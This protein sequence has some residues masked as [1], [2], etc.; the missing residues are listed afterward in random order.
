[1]TVEVKS[2]KMKISHL[3]RDFKSGKLRRPDEYQRG[4]KWLT[5]QKQKFIDSL[6]RNY[7]VP[8]I[9]LHSVQQ[10]DASTHFDIVDGQQ[11]LAALRDYLNPEKPLEV[12]DVNGR[13]RMR[14]PQGI[15]EQ[16][17]PW[18]GRNFH[19]LGKELQLDFL[20]REIQVHVI[21]TANPHEVRDLFI[22]LQ[23]GTP[24]AP[25]QIRD[26][27]PGNL[28][29]YVEQLGGKFNAS[30]RCGL[31][32]YID[33]RGDKVASDDDLDTGRRDPHVIK[34]Q[35]C[36]Q[37]L[38]IYLRR[39]ENLKDVPSIGSK[40]L[41]QFYYVDAS[42]PSEAQKDAAKQFESLLNQTGQVVKNAVAMLYNKRVLPKLEVL[43]LFMFFQE[44]RK[45]Y[46]LEFSAK[47]LEELTEF[48]ATYEDDFSGSRTK[49]STISGHYER[50][51]RKL[52]RKINLPEIRFLKDRHATI[53][54]DDSP[55]FDLGSFD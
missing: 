42:F 49:S 38:L 51:L 15:R 25:Q 13:T 41:D 37:L 22:R 54:E 17:A 12:P 30:P 19:S 23:A 24:L 39:E 45:S 50:W 11:R 47:F 9:F 52:D 16:D 28:S 5:H 21:T 48:V 34:R 43:S 7:P 3:V 53:P 14:L 31:F 35:V 27:W 20:N 32:N 36:A 8:A 26:A 46:E 10:S 6:F 18:A 29:A 44:A 1:M 4:E 2:R 40:Q 33:G 55:S